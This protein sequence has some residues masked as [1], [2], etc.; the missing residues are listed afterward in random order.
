MYAINILGAGIPG[1]MMVF[2][3]HYAE[4]YVLWP[5]Q[6]YGVMA[7]LGS[8][9]LTIGGVSVLGLRDPLRFIPI[10]LVQLCYK[11]IWLIT[12]AFPAMQNENVPEAMYFI[13]GIFVLLIVEFVFFIRPSDFNLHI[14]QKEIKAVESV[15][16]LA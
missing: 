13:V 15:D 3:P 6:D 9:W 16:S 4:T 8:I 2:F 12:Y 1:F 10:F 14:P 7:I 11:S 5:G